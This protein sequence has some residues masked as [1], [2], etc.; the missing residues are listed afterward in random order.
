M[1]GNLYW[2][3]PVGPVVAYYGQPEAA[4]VDGS[5]E[6]HR[7]F[8]F[9]ASAPAPESGSI[10]QTKS[11]LTFYMIGLDPA[12]A[13]P[14]VIQGVFNPGSTPTQ[15]AVPMVAQGVP[16]IQNATVAST[17]AYA[18]S[19]NN[20]LTFNEYDSAIHYAGERVSADGQF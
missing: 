2:V 18:V 15:P 4:G 6:G 7:Q 8:L 11:Q 20:G 14:L 10:D 16:Q 1:Y 9:S 19:W 13:S 3:N 12:K 5:G 17:T